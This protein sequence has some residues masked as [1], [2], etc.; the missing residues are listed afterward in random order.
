[1]SVITTQYTSLCKVTSASLSALCVSTVYT[2]EG[3]TGIHYT[4]YTGEG[5]TGGGRQVMVAALV[6]LLAALCA[7]ALIIV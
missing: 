1:M 2:G 4:V 5:S 6:P 7:L 3:S